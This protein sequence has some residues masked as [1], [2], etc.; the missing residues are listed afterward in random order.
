MLWVSYALI[1]VQRRSKLE[2]LK[3][4]EDL[5]S[6]TQK[7]IDQTVQLNEQRFQLAMKIKVWLHLKPCS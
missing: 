7:L 4:D 1:P 2:A 3:G 5:T 6:A